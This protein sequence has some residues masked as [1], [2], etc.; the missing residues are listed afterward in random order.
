MSS[1]E[2]KTTK[3]YKITND[4]K[5]KLERLAEES[6]LETQEAFIEQLASMYELQL[7]K[8]GTGSGYAK[9]IDELEYHTRRNAEIFIGMI[10]T[11]A[12][13]RLNL[14]QQHTDALANR[15]E[16]IFAQEQ[17]ITEMKKE[18]K[19][20]A[21][22]MGRLIKENGSQAKLVEQLQ[23][24]VRDKGLIVEQRGQEISTL[25]GI[26]N[27]YKAAAD[28]N[29]ELKTEI[30]RLTEVVNNQSGRIAGLETQVTT[31]EAISEK[32]L[33]EA[34]ERHKEA[35][36]R[37]SERKDMEKERELLA[38]RTEYQAKLEKEREDATGKLRE[39]YEQ[40]DLLREE[41]AKLKQ[42]KSDDG[43]KSS[44]KK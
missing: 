31:L 20:L 21:D 2:A 28:E 30:S 10:N 11:E 42:P 25:S 36:E 35:L 40:R 13:E 27:E 9:Q 17:E 7:L 44:E 14:S 26:V 38:I 43:G 6:G 24:S 1:T 16:T 34:E 22:E 19:A 29:K 5:V 8:Q 15:A 3:A 12:A 4:L 33:T 41:I 32:Q 23:E 18:V 37:L 39:Q